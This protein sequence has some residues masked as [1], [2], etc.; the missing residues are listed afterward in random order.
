MKIFVAVGN[1]FPFDRLIKTIDLWAGNR[2]EIAVTAQIGKSNYHP[3]NITSYETLPSV[4]FNRIF[5]ESDLIISHAG[6]GLIIKAL[7]EGKPIVVFPR[8]HRLGEHT[9]DHQMA[10]ARAFKKMDYVNVALNESELKNYLDC[11]YEISSKHRIGLY[12]S[13]GLIDYLRQFINEI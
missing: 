5:S 9:T 10:T 11:L 8:Q 6:M 7:T 12:A 4:E 2:T 1:I 3:K 13:K